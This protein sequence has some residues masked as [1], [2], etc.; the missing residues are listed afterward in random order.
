MSFDAEAQARVK[1]HQ[2]HHDHAGYNASAGVCLTCADTSKD[3]PFQIGERW[4]SYDNG[5]SWTRQQVA[6]A[7]SELAMTVVKVDRTRG[8]ITL[9]SR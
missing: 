4:Y 3:S 1:W 5:H 8:E 6:M 2:D 7:T 9:S